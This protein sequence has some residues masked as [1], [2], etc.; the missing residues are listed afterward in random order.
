LGLKTLGIFNAESFVSVT[1]RQRRYICFEPPNF[2]QDLRG[3]MCKLEK[4]EIAQYRL[5]FFTKLSDMTIAIYPVNYMKTHSRTWH[6][7]ESCS[8]KKKTT[9]K[10]NF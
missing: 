8:R 10:L 7:P 3:Y 9:L 4:L 2:K 6:T 1:F 5:T